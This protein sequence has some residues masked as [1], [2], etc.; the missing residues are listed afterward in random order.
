MINNLYHHVINTKKFLNSLVADILPEYELKIYGSYSTQLSLPWS[1]LDLVLMKKSS[2]QQDSDKQGNIYYNLNYLS[3]HLINDSRFSFCKYIDSASVPIIKLVYKIENIDMKIDI[4]YQ[5]HRHQGQKCVNLIEYFKQTYEV[6][7]YIVLF[8][9]QILK[10]NQLNDPFLGGL[11]SY[12]VTLMVIS[13]LQKEQEKPYVDLKLSNNENLGKIFVEFLKYY[14][15][16][17]EKKYVISIK[18]PDEFKDNS[19]SLFPV[20]IYILYSNI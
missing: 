19:N 8:I 6:F 12:A 9:K 4:T 7:E 15:N 14:S 20:C 16:F 3:S 5:D 17:D 11:S 1:D 13:F 10:N 2:F 18:C